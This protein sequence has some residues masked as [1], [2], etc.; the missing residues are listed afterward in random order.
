ME[1]KWA[2]SDKRLY[3]TIFLAHVLGEENAE[4]VSSTID[5]V[6][7]ILW[8]LGVHDGSCWYGG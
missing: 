6:D 2:L 3:L 1:N 8:I 7:P 5:S 4:Y